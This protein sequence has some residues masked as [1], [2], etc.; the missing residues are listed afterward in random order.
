MLPSEFVHRV[1][2]YCTCVDGWGK[3]VG[4]TCRSWGSLS[5]ACP[6]WCLGIA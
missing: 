6:H 1:S 4:K 5:V 2:Q 3:I